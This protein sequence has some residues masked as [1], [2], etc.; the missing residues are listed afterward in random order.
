[1]KRFEEPK[2]EILN[3]D[4]I[5]TDLPTIHQVSSEPE[6]GWGPLIG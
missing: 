4:E 1:M 5:L 3:L 6:T 2:M